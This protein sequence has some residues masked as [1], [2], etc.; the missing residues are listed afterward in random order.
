MTYELSVIAEYSDWALACMIIASNLEE[1]GIAATVETYDFGVWYD[2]LQKGEFDLSPGF[3]A[4]GPT[5]YNVYRAIMSTETVR[6]VGQNALENWHRFGSAEA[7][8][9]LEQFAAT[10]DPQAQ[11]ELAG[12]LQLLFVEQA[13]AIPL[14][15]SPQ[16][17]EYNSRR[18]A[19]FPDQDN[20]YAQLS[21]WAAPDRLLV[22]TSIQPA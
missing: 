9:L 16:W 3:S 10:A 5:P 17:G 22:M 4:S 2:R 6:P 18:F 12:Q 20:P 8:R 1:V 14:F 13:P 21:P 19:G 11:R 7:D 15:P